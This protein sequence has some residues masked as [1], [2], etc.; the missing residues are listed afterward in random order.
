[1]DKVQK[2]ISEAATMV[3]KSAS[4][5]D[6][7]GLSMAEV[8]GIVSQGHLTPDYAPNGAGNG[9]LAQAVRYANE[10]TNRDGVTICGEKVSYRGS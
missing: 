7:G 9:N 5:K 10:D 2:E 3:P 1:M 6:A 8:R 4:M